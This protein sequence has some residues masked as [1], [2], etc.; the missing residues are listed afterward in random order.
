MSGCISGT[1]NQIHPQTNNGCTTCQSEMES[2]GSA[3]FNVNLGNHLILHSIHF[4]SIKMRLMTLA[5]KDV[6][7]D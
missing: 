5:V 2:P 7:D 3:G 4:S 1:T 6:G